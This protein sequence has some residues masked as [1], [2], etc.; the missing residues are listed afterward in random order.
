MTFVPTEK[1]GRVSIHDTRLQLDDSDLNTD[2]L[3]GCY[4]R[5]LRVSGMKG[6]GPENGK[7]LGSSY[8]L[9]NFIR[10]VDFFDDFL[11]K[12]LS[13]RWT[14]LHGTDGSAASAID[15][16]QANGAVVLTTGAGSTHT[17]AVNGSGIAANRNFLISNGGTVFE[18]RLGNI[19]AL[20]SQCIFFGLSDADTLLSAFTRT[21]TTTTANATNGVGFLQDAASTNTH[22]YAVAVNAGGSPQ[23][24]ALGVDV[25]TA[26]YHTYRVEIDA[27]GNANFFIDGLQVGTILLAVATTA[28]LTPGVN[29]FSE[30]TSA[31]QTLL[32]DYVWTQ[33]LRV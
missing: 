33:C 17:E 9:D 11:G 19:S 5:G 28:L 12:T 2:F 29:M 21:T 4:L 13:T 6:V 18:T 14:A 15:A 16:D 26:K 30:A 3:T 10:H 27:L 22:L 7:V 32:I 8:K 20:T 25:D 24:V 1:Y 23:S 31:S